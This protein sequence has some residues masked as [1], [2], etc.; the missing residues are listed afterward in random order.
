[1]GAALRIFGDMRRVPS[2]RTPCIAQFGPWLK[3]R[4]SG[5]AP[6]LVAPKA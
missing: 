5:R 4:L 2:P 3:K 1:M 6:A